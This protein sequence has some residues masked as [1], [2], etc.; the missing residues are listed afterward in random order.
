M[1]STA[2]KVLPSNLCFSKL[3]GSDRNSQANLFLG[4]TKC[5]SVNV[6]CKREITSPNCQYDCPMTTELVS[7][8]ESKVKFESDSKFESNSKGVDR[9]AFLSLLTALSFSAIGEE[10]SAREKRK[11]KTIPEEEYK[12]AEDGLKYYD[13][14]DGKGELAEKGSLVSVHFDCVYKS[15]TVVSSRESKLL[16]GNRVI[17]QAYDF[18]VG[19]KPGSE[20][21]RDPTDS[22]NG[23]FSAQAS[24]KPPRAL[25]AL[26]EG[27]HVGG[28]RTVVVTPEEGYGDRGFAEIPPGAIFELNIELLEVKKG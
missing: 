10:A 11:P 19:S 22:A 28:K 17:A 13:F 23:L 15:L 9:R 8:S 27:M 14:V 20:R 25:Y 4:K 12:I 1:A 2:I 7:K 5:V 6:C 16:G 18:I 3:Y 24:P 21:K 26:T